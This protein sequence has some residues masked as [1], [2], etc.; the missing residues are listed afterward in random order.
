MQGSSIMKPT[1][2][3]RAFG[4]G[5][6]AGAAAAAGG[7]AFVTLS[8]F[9]GRPA[10]AAPNLTYLTWGGYDLPEFDG[11]FIAKHGGQPTATFFADQ[12]EALE[13]V[14]A[15]FKADVVHPCTETVIRWRLANLLKPIDTARVTAWN[16]IW[17][18]LK[19]LMGTTDES[20]NVFFVPFEWGNSSVIYRTD[21]VDPAYLEDES[22]GIL[23]DERY[24]GRIS[25]YDEA[26][27]AVEV[28]G[29]VLGYEN[30]FSMDD[31]QL[32]EVRKLLLKQRELNRFYWGDQ[33]EI[34]QALASGELVAAYA[35]NSAVVN[36]KK[37]GV[38]VAYANP[39]EGIRTWVCGMVLTNLGE[40]DEGQAYDFINSRLDPSSG[41]N[42]ITMYGYGHSN[43]KT[44]EQVDPKV[45]EELG[46]SDPG[47]MLSRSIFLQGEEPP[48]DKIYVDL[49]DE[50]KAGS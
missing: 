6:G 11:Q 34:E 50:V 35:W 28:A 32:A 44:F 26:A 30:I 9:A 22:W 49:F 47:S 17:P 5:L 31:A 3:R 27:A 16:D 37:E 24:K 21:L 36:L 20:G 18:D 25:M 7:A 33:T 19:G 45:L 10:Q 46:I 48:F 4:A 2:T 14:R 41:V 12:D 43:M 39:K 23:F 42:L 15:G 13:K 29:Q 40:G 8:S 1:M 38:P